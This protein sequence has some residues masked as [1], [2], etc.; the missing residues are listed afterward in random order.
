[1]DRDIPDASMCSFEM[2]W[3]P[4]WV[5]HFSTIPV[6]SNGLYSKKYLIL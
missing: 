4:F 3:D 2:N 1:M 5:P 6:D